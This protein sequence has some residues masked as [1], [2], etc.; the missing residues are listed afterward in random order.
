MS[1]HHFGVDDLSPIFKDFSSHSP[2]LLVSLGGYFGGFGTTFEFSNV[3]DA[4]D[5]KKLYVRDIRRAVYHTGLPGLSVDVPSTTEVLRGLIAESGAKRVTMIGNSQGGFAAIMFGALLDIDCV[6]AFS[7]QT[8]VGPINRW[9]HGE[10]RWPHVAFQLYFRSLF[11][12][13]YYDMQKLLN[14]TRGKTQFQIHYG[15]KEP[16]EAVNAEY[17]RGCRGVTLHSYPLSKRQ[18]LKHMIDSG[19]FEKILHG[20]ADV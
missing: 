10:N 19:L 11:K 9:R 6:H 13:K 3:A 20:T 17:L 15:L 5:V 7:A 2:H 12:R 8:F 16:L 1:T 4:A 18:L 14:A